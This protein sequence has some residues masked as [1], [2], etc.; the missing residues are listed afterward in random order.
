LI[1]YKGDLD[2]EEARERLY[3]KLGIGGGVADIQ[4]QKQD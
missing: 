4:I 2:E 3:G 1:I